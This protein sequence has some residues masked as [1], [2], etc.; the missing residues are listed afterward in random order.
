[1]PSLFSRL[2]NPNSPSTH[3]A[4][5]TASGA[6]ILLAGFAARAASSQCL[7]LPGD[8]N[9]PDAE[10]WAKL[11]STLD[12]RLSATLP[13]GHVCHDPTYDADAC[14]ALQQAWTKPGTQF[15]LAPL[16]LI[17]IHGGL[18]YRPQLELVFVCHAV[19]LCQPELRPLYGTVDTVPTRQLCELRCQ[20]LL[21][22]RRP[23]RS[24]LHQDEQDPSRC[25]QHGP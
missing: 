15:V 5:K 24:E 21:R 20:C 25:A 8:A 4:M 23:G 16:T 17:D 1:V 14:A 19:V 9:W 13:I 7:A 11:N 3:S 10:A 12:G 2:E 18:T 6:A 22:C